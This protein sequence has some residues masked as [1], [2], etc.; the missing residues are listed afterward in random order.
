[1]ALEFCGTGGTGAIAPARSKS[2]QVN[3]ESKALA[4]SQPLTVL[5]ARK[6]AS[7][8]SWRVLRGG[9]KGEWHDLARKSMRSAD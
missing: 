6:L 2:A 5:L 7:T 9:G 8:Y 4:T 1:M 3:P